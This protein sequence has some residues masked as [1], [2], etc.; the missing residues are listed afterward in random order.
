MSENEKA[1]L[2]DKIMSDIHENAYNYHDFIMDV[3]VEHV[4]SWDLDDMKDF[5]GIEEEDE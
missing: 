1:E 2:V 3:V 5:L 4:K